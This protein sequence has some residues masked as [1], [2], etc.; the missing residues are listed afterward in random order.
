MKNARQTLKRVTSQMCH[1]WNSTAKVTEYSGPDTG[2]H[3][4]V[5]QNQDFIKTVIQIIS[6]DNMNI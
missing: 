6:E 5:I 1:K 3:D 2:E 4:K